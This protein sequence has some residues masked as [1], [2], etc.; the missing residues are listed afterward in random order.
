LWKNVSIFEE[1]HGFLSK[2]CSIVTVLCTISIWE[3]HVLTRFDTSRFLTNSNSNLFFLHRQSSA[4]FFA[5]EDIV[6]Q[7][8]FGTKQT[9][10]HQKTTPTIMLDQPFFYDQLEDSPDEYAFS[11]TSQERAYYQEKVMAAEEAAS[12]R[13]AIERRHHLKQ[14]K[15]KEKIRR[16]QESIQK[17]RQY[18]LEEEEFCRAYEAAKLRRLQAEAGFRRQ[19][20]AAV[21]SE[22]AQYYDTETKEGETVQLVRGP[23]GR[24]YRINMPRPSQHSESTRELAAGRRG[25]ASAADEIEMIIA[26]LFQGEKEQEEKLSASII[27]EEPVKLRDRKSEYKARQAFQQR[28]QASAARGEEEGDGVEQNET[29]KEEPAFIL[30][31]DPNGRVIRI[32]KDRRPQNCPDLPHSVEEKKPKSISAGEEEPRTMREKA[33]GL[34][35][36]EKSGKTIPIRVPLPCHPR[37]RYNRATS[38]QEQQFNRRKE[39]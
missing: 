25:A 33:A 3:K 4:E 7:Y 10:T 19:Q 31:V 32:S 20:L 15:I 27:S 23:D 36:K 22:R 13:A 38:Y 6:S 14:L 21:E 18:K 30:M 34:D 39:E 5:D 28:Q 17:L 26:G 12:H 37:C 8:C 29:A 2:H 24:L 35:I 11:W 9:T 16:Q 1:F